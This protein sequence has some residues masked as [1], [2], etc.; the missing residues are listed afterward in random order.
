M[1]KCFIT[2]L[3][4]LLVVGLTFAQTWTIGGEVKTGI[5]WERIESRVDGGTLEETVRLH[6]M[7]DA[8]PAD[9][10]FRLNLGF[11]SSTGNVGFNARLNW[12][13]FNNAPTLGPN[14]QHAYGWGL[15]FNNQL[16]MS[17][18]MLGGSPWGTG[19]P[20]MWQE[21]E[22]T[23]TG[24][25]R[26]EWMPNFVPGHLNLGFVLNWIDGYA[27]AGMDR[28]PT[29]M[30]FLMESVL[31]VSYRNDWFYVRIGYRLDSEMDFP[32]RL[33]VED[34]TEGDRMVYRVEEFV[35]QRF[36]PDLSIWALG[37]FR[38]IGTDVPELL[39]TTTNWLFIQYAPEAFTADLRFGLDA[40]GT[41]YIYHIRA[42]FAYNLD[43]GGIQIVP[44]FRF[45]FANDF[46]EAQLVPGSSFSHIGIHPSV[47]VNFT[48]NMHVAFAYYW[49][50]EQWFGAPLPPERQR[51]RI[52][53]RAGVTF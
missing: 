24:G 23:P 42:G 20:E 40:R 2:I 13:N 31:G 28:D 49:D 45:L 26:F 52:N 35:L 39:F 11:T 36:V 30:D 7:D 5:L 8:G 43:V 47:Q 1:K 9:G 16:R 48:P 17:L 33:G 32:G 4:T 18:G 29:I 38:G 10:R 22:V 34:V 19:G 44:R 21:L 50:L 51:Q 12:E 37:Y 25:M 41:R 14:W 6:S 15:A 27:D 53:L 3:L 46:G